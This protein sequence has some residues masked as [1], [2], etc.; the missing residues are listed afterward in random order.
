MLDSARALT[1][2]VSRIETS[3][4]GFCEE[5]GS[6]VLLLLN[7]KTSQAREGFLYTSTRL[8]MLISCGRT[9]KLSRDKVF[10]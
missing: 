1:F 7:G 3:G 6:L 9:M 5:R 10:I 8:V 4:V 2:I